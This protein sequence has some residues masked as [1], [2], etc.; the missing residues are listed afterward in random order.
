MNSAVIVAAGKGK[1]FGN[2]IPKQFRKI[3]DR[4]VIDYSLSKFINHSNIDEV[5]IDAGAAKGQNDPLIIHTKEVKSK[6][7]KTSA[8]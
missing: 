5:I 6:T 2:G 1:R 7:E 8:A 3:L 4:D